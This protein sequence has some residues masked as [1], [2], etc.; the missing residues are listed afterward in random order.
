MPKYNDNLN[1][2]DFLSTFLLNTIKIKPTGF[3]KLDTEWYF[4]HQQYL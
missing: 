1:Q 2:D 3:F 4:I